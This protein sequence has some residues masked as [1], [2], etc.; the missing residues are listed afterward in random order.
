MDGNHDFHKYTTSSSIL[1]LCIQY[2]RMDMYIFT[3]QTAMQMINFSH[4][5][6]RSVKIRLCLECTFYENIEVNLILSREN[7]YLF[8]H[9][10]PF[11]WWV[12]VEHDFYTEQTGVTWT[13]RGVA[14][15][16]FSMN[17]VWV[18]HTISSVPF[19]V[20]FVND[21]LMSVQL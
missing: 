7:K 18:E 20:I 17:F 2:T 15:N 5:M 4:S 16:V 8:M 3:R 13:G 14:S 12:K 1:T 10:L 19:V 6:W 11:Y 21:L 9:S